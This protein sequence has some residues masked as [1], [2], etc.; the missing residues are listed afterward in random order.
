MSP[1]SGPTAAPATAARSSPATSPTVG[2]TPSRRPAT[3][4]RTTPTTAGPAASR[5][6]TAAPAAPATSSET[7]RGA[8]ERPAA[9]SSTASARLSST[10]NGLPMNSMI[11]R[12]LLL[13]SALSG[14][15]GA[16]VVGEPRDGGGM[17]AVGTD[18]GGADASCPSG[19]RS[20]GGRCV[21]P[22]VAPAHCGGCGMPCA[23]GQACVAG[24]CELRCPG[25]QAVCSGQCF[26]L[27]TDSAHCGACG[28]ACPSGQV[29]SLGRCSA[30][31]DATLTTCAGGDGGAAS[32]CSDTRTDGLNCG[33]CGRACAAGSVC[34]AGVCELS[35]AGNQRAC[36][37]SCRDL[38]TDDAHC[39]ACGNACPPG[40]TCSA[41]ACSVSCGT[42]LTA[43]GATCTNLQTDRAHCGSC[44][45]ACPAGQL[46]SGG[47]C[48]ATCARPATT[49][50]DGT[51]RYCADTA[52]DPAHCGSCER[53]CALPHTMTQGCTGGECAVV[54]CDATYGDCDGVASNGC[55]TDTASSAAHCGGCGRACL[56]AHA[57]SS[58]GS[59]EC[60]VVA[61]DPGFADCDRVA[62]NGCEVDTRTDNANCGACGAGCA[63]G[64]VCS[65]GV[66]GAT[67][68]APLAT[69]G[70]A[71]MA[72]CANTAIDPTNCGA[73]GTVCAL[74]NVMSHGCAGGM[75][76]PA[77]CAAGYGDCDGL[78]S[79]GCETDLTASAPHCGA[80]GRACALPNATAT[81][82]VGACAVM[83]CAAGYA[84][85]DRNPANGCEVDTRT[86][87][88]S[89]GACGTACAAGQVCSGGTCGATCAAP[90]ITC[91]A[92]ATA[93]CANTAINPAN[94]GACGMVCSLPGVTAVGCAAGACTVVRCSEGAGDCNGTAS[95]GCET[96]LR[97]SEE[98]CGAC[99]RACALPH[100]SATCTGGSCAVAA[101]AAGFADCD[102]DPTNGC[103]VHTATDN[104]SCGA[105]GTACA[106]GQVCS[107]GVCGATCASPL[108]T[109][110]T[111]ATAFCANTAIDPTNCGECGAVCALS[112]V[113]ANGCA[114][115]ACTAVRCVGGFGDCD[116]AASNGCETDLSASATSCGACGRTCTLPHATSTCTSGSCAVMACAS[117]FADCD[118]DP[119][120]G[121]EVHTA[122]DNTS[123]GACGTACAAGQVCSGGA[124]GATCA[125][126]L[127]TCGTG[128]T[129][130]CANAAIDP[131]N[132][133]ECG[134]V[135]ALSHVAANGCASGACTVV[136]CSGGFGDCDGASS[137]GCETDLNASA[138]SCG[139]CG[140]ACVLANASSTCASG[141]CAIAACAAGFADCNANPSDG[142]EVDTRS[143]STSC[144]ACGTAC[145]AGQVCSGGACG[146]TCASPLRSCGM[147]SSAF[148]ANTA[149]DPANCGGCGTVCA[150]SNASAQGCSAGACTVVRCAAG[151]G[152]CD[153][154]ASNGCETNVQ[155]TLTSCG[156]CGRACALPN[157]TAACTAGG[158]SLVACAAG[159]ADCNANP[160]DGCEVDTRSDNASCGAC[161]TACPAGR[162]CSGG[163][164]GATCASPLR[165]CGT[166]ASAFCANTAID[167]SHCGACGTV[168]ALSHVAAQ[169]CAAG[170][171]T[172]VR[173]TGGYGDCDGV[174]S[175]GCETDLAASATSC[176]ACGRACVLANASSRCSSGAC[177]IT[178]CAAG[179]LDCDGLAANGCEVDT[180]SD[181]ANCGACRVACA[182]GRVC[183]AGSCG[184]S[185]APPLRACGAGATAFCANTSI[186]PSHCGE[187]GTVCALPNVA[188]N[189]CSASACTVL[190]C[191]VGFGDCDGVASN[192][193]ETGT[194]T[195]ATSCG[196]CGRTCVL[197]NATSACAAGACAITACAPGFA[198]CD[199]SAANGCEV[200]TRS[201]NTNCGACG[202]GCAA[203][204]V[205]SAGACGTSCAS[206]LS[207]CG[208]GATA[209]CA[210]TAIDPA[211]CGACGT[212]CALPN[213]AATGCSAGACTVVRCAAGY[214]DCDGSPTNG[215]E[216][217]TRSNAASCGVC[218][219]VCSLPNASATCSSGACAIAACTPGYADCDGL[220]ANGCEV[221]TGTDNAN[222]GACGRACGGGAIC[223]GG[224]CGVSCSAGQ[225]NCS[226]TCSNLA[227][228]PL[229]CGSCT[230]ACPVRASA[231]AY[232]TGGTCGF[233]CYAGFGNCDGA[234][235]NGC[236][237][238]LRSSA[239]SCGACGNACTLSNATSVCSAGACS[240]TACSSGF[241]NCDGSQANGCETHTL[242]SSAHCGGCGIT[243]SSIQYCGG[244]RCQCPSGQRPVGPYCVPSSAAPRLLA[245]MSLGDVTQRRPT[246]RWT[247]PSGFDGAEVA[248]C[249]DRDCTISLEVLTVS[250]S[251]AR[252]AVDLPA[253]GVVFWRVRGRIGSV[254]DTTA[255]PTWLFHVPAR[256]ASSGVDSS[257]NPHLDLN[258]D[259]YDDM[260]A[261]AARASPPQGSQAGSVAVFHGS[262]LGLAT[263]PVRVIEGSESYVQLGQSVASAGDVNGD[264]YG[265]LI[266]SEHRANGP[267][268]S[269]A[270]AA[271][272][273]HGSPTGVP[274]NATTVLVGGQ[275]F[276]F[277][278]QSLAGAGDV[279]GDGYADVVVGTGGARTASVFHGSAS[280]IVMSPARVLVGDFYDDTF[281]QS[282]ASAGDVNGDGYTDLIIGAY[283]A[284]PDGGDTVGTASIFH[285][286]PS[287]IG[288]T[289]ARVLRGS[290]PFSQFGRS[291]ASAGDVNA[292]GYVDVIV[293][294][295]GGSP[296][297]ASVFMGSP[298][299]VE[300][301]AAR[302]LL[303]ASGDTIGRTVAGAGDVNGDGYDDVVSGGTRPTSFPS[304]PFVGFA[305]VFHGGPS[306]VSPSASLTLVGARGDDTFGF[307]LAGAGDHSGDGY[308]D[309]LIGSFNAF[310]GAG[311]AFSYRG[312]ASGV[313]RDP[314][315]TFVGTGNYVYSFGTSVASAVDLR[316]RPAVLWCVA[317]GPRRVTALSRRA[318]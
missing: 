17:D 50:G 294:V 101:C 111:G 78:A 7:R 233:A 256:S 44:G 106:A 273:F 282:V 1:A 314:S 148:C 63:A 91:G 237:T 136:R 8:G 269:Y 216:T 53:A 181:N 87:N 61:C 302:V 109:C 257:D 55:E 51:A 6:A 46:C 153:G 141:A 116:G 204:R 102:R 132:C 58:C 197:P 142:C 82:T 38:Q 189:G 119:T 308:G 255:S 26:N 156:A 224:A 293:G 143:D 299:G 258:G 211:H 252:P 122:T 41:G 43:C 18:G 239:T 175:N 133:G 234:A 5:A 92:G 108:S 23:A 88:A 31:C 267:A 260:A 209:F 192:G 103:E 276:E 280:G 250:G 263:T 165:T 236:E 278:G 287:G 261:G 107:G 205:C 248:L 317:P 291:V 113:A 279:N 40:N 9:P 218:G 170:A 124:C 99:G 93:Y 203:G 36:G 297:N 83:A 200:D 138:S 183:S 219:R 288:T 100:A 222:C 292:D 144:G 232:C 303:G 137:N 310:A 110:G 164:C 28:R 152:D 97:T 4:C 150:L 129:A 2:A 114:A 34:I 14:C 210:N 245:P 305:S 171:C 254:T 115:G 54:R 296:S 96:N 127:S 49:C 29:C 202:T 179:F 19:Q 247:L 32:Y 76:T 318:A 120:N 35:C 206:P 135:C 313:E 134:T 177:A 147:G 86:D 290:V 230:T 172:V 162:V 274:P 65:G 286:S 193:C 199:L 155:T 59:G 194:L 213:V 69:C 298:S 60:A 265:D 57:R 315:R 309:I 121:C 208:A 67:C 139:A 185:C 39:G 186:D 123:C 105:C 243:C 196:A 304:D 316:G 198:D 220:A 131:A 117:G 300:A 75:C 207:T 62:S 306:G 160:S 190:R 182:S 159:F 48:G 240:I 163:T 212:V 52:I 70:T 241:G 228:D 149:L 140:R 295:P 166:G 77:R 173:C 284:R 84:D 214:G 24:A 289:A 253:N 72:F 191:A 10:Q 311:A 64:S 21:D 42:G 20:C 27:Q 174:S 169:G 281:G 45:A 74:A 22:A 283:Q 312:S 85:C 112:H 262:A 80:C 158:C 249:R 79:N 187:C 73:C 126:P 251:T 118:R 246:L 271:R 71:P 259:G 25:T 90:R 238:D 89:C 154:A 227:S 270:G 184:T 81:C 242:T 12:S 11:L 268:G 3:T 307:A 301:S 176:G 151:Y 235:S 16:S 47:R 168:C 272:V 226:G 157:A 215:C 145:A 146:T 225:T 275:S 30:S 15:V 188:A 217:D 266:L 161:G 180:R 98:S 229:R 33:A 13:L 264:G 125:S 95:D 195:S 167:P 244:G 128:A 37:G 201:D 94:C 277:F 178:T 68:A 221:G 223:S 231:A 130:F 104:T 56:L 66:C 285:G